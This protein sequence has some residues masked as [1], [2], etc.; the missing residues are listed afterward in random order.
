VPDRVDITEPQEGLRFGVDETGAVEL[1]ALTGAV[2]HPLSRTMQ[3]TGTTSLR[4]G[5]VLNLVP[6]TG[7][8][9]VASLASGIGR[10]APAL[11]TPAELAVQMVRAPA[12]LSFPP[13]S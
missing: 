7:T 10:P 2:G 8:G 12:R 9:L 6:P 1:R 3:V 5:R 4:E 13:Q 11:L